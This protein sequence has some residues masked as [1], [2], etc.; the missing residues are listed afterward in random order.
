MRC[1]HQFANPF[2]LQTGFDSFV[3]RIAGIHG[4]GHENCC[5]QRISGNLHVLN[6]IAFGIKEAV[7][8]DS[9]LDFVGL[10]R[11]LQSR[12]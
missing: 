12:F 6:L 2:H 1:L 5:W 4:V 11:V 3:K 8:K 7:A 10:A 9:T